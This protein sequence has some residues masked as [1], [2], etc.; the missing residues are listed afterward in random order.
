[1]F[2]DETVTPRALKP[3]LLDESTRKLVEIMVSVTPAQLQ[4]VEDFLRTRCIEYNVKPRPV[5][6][7]DLELY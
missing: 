3:P 6:L 4:V 5:T 7:G 1:M 2:I